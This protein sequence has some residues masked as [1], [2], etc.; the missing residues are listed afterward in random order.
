[1]KC[2]TIKLWDILDCFHYI[3][4][5]PR[6]SQ[7]NDI[8]QYTVNRMWIVYDGKAYTPC[9]NVCCQKMLLKAFLQ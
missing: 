9:K 5:A 8:L 1:M 2:V 7:R 3:L 6:I 4:S